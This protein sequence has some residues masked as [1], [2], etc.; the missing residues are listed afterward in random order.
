MWIFG[1]KYFINKLPRVLSPYRGGGI[2]YLSDPDSYAGWSFYTPDRAT[3]ML[4]GVFTLLIGVSESGFTSK[5][6]IKVIYGRE[7]HR[8]RRS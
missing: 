5:Q 4:T 3:A 7:K 2:E 8:K 6:C 1:V